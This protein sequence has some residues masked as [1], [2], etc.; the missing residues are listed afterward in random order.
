MP[1]T[2][3]GESKS[4]GVRS[5]GLG[6]D[7]CCFIPGPGHGKSWFQPGKLLHNRPFCRKKGLMQISK[8]FLF[9]CAAA[10]CV[11]LLPLCAAD[12]DTTL[13]LREAMEKKLDELQTQPP[14]TA[15]KPA[16]VAPA[17]AMAPA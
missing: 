11:A 12:S 15:K 4:A 1:S 14:A 13:K 10:Y 9:V 7:P 6:C 16:V 5:D 8:S 2:L 17:P 3:R